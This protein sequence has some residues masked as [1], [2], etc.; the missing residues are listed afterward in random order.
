MRKFGI[1]Y[2]RLH[3]AVPRGACGI[4]GR[5]QT[6]RLVEG[7]RS[8]VRGRSAGPHPGLGGAAVAAIVAEQEAG[9]RYP[10]QKV[11]VLKVMSHEQYDRDKWKDECGCFQ[12][13]PTRKATRSGIQRT[14]R[15]R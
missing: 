3:P 9:N 11:F 8:L 6:G 4:C 1:K 2:S 15:R 7:A 12:P 10:S 13:P 5:P 14:R